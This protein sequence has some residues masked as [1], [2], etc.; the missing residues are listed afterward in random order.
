MP[1]IKHTK[2]E[3]KTQQENLQLFNR[4]LPMLQLKKKLLQTE[5]KHV[6]NV[7]REEDEKEKSMLDKLQSW[8]HVFADAADPG[9]YL[10]LKAVKI[11]EDN[12]AGVAVPVFEQVEFE[13]RKPDLFT[14]PPWLD[15]ALLEMERLIALREKK[16]V[17][18][19]QERLITA[20]LITTSQRVNLFEK[21]KI[22]ETNENIRIIKIFLGDEQTAAV[23][24]SKIA[25]DRLQE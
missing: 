17:L 21:V 8:V 2:N 10:S 16:N 1:K 12:V 22:P 20:E 5:I 25:K 7:R 3:L 14:T 11:T 9:D 23:V 4:F 24:R 6:Q 13:R 18:S 19:E 15:D